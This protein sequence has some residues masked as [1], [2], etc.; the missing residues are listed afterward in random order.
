MKGNSF[1]RKHEL[2]AT[3]FLL[4]SLLFVIKAVFISEQI[5]DCIIGATFWKVS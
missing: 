3:S 5:S 1:P 4:S 2:L